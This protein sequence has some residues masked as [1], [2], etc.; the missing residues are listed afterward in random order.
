MRLIIPLIIIILGMLTGALVCRLFN[1]TA[2]GFK[3][4]V[5]AGGFGAFVGLIVRDA[6]DIAIGGPLGGAV[7]AAIAGAV[8][9]SAVTNRLF[10][11]V[12]K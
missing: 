1:E 6:M 4:S 8:V 5:I 10:G 9:F 2:T 7:L 11:K 3:L 12:G